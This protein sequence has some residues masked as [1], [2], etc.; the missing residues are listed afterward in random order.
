[1]CKYNS[2]IAGRHHF[3]KAESLHFKRMETEHKLNNATFLLVGQLRFVFAFVHV[4]E[5]D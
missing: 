5:N 2:S 4:V 1:M 3:G